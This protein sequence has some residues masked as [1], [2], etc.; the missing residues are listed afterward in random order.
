MASEHAPLNV[1]GKYPL[2]E[3]KM[4]ER[5]LDPARRIN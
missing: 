1:L 5:L 3:F 2:V 4:I